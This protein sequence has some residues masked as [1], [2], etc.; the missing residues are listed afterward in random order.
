M[1]KVLSKDYPLLKEEKANI[2]ADLETSHSKN[3]IFLPWLKGIQVW[4]K[5]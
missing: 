3:W 4:D 1:Y 2:Q 5:N